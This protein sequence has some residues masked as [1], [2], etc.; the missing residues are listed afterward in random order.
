[1]KA[2]AIDS[3][4]SFLSLYAVNSDKTSEINIFAPQQQSEKLISLIEQTFN[5]IDVSAKDL[6]F[7]VASLGPG[8]FTG[9]RL[10]FATLKALS[11][12]FDIPF[13]GLSTLLTMAYPY[14]NLPFSIM[15]VIDARKERFY[16][17]LYNQGKQIIA[18]DDKSVEDIIQKLI[19]HGQS[20]IMVVGHDAKLFCK[21]AE[22]FT[23]IQFLNLTQ[24][25]GLAQSL[26][27]QGGDLFLQNAPALS[28]DASPLYIRASEAEENYKDFNQTDKVL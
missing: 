6:D 15:P 16:F 7:I 2:F 24:S 1:M 28:K 18:D 20:Q 21:K 14:K 9:L 10:A 12:A 17:S 22:S 4:S 25:T 19:D 3:S 27:E 11:F 13:Y 5:H 23:N 26:F 8:S